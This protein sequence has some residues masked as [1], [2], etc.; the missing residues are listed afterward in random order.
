MFETISDKKC[1]NA[2]V[3]GANAKY[4]GVILACDIPLGWVVTRHYCLIGAFN[5]S[6]HSAD[7][8]GVRRERY[9]YAFLVELLRKGESLS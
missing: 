5:F 2:Y 3:Q 9:D 1:V 7:T 4:N 8:M 6:L